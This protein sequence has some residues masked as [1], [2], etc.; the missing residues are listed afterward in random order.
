V[1]HVKFLHKNGLL[2][3]KLGSLRWVCI[4][5]GGRIF[6]Q[7]Q[8]FPSVV[9]GHVVDPNPGDKILDMCAAPGGKTTHLVS[10]L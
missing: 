7:M 5:L 3:M 4:D 10:M 2:G 9:C 8:N 6:F 1:F